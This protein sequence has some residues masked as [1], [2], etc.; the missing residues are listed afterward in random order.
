MLMQRLILLVS[1]NV[2]NL[3]SI[4]PSSLQL[5]IQILEVRNKM[6][7]AKRKNYFV[8]AIFFKEVHLKSFLIPD[9]KQQG[10]KK[11]ISTIPNAKRETN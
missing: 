10:K 5:D 4:S 11:Q 1:R 9:S 7:L 8:S 3:A 6:L 2:T